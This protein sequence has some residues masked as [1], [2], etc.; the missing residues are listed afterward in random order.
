MNLFESIET[1]QNELSQ[2]TNPKQW[3]KRNQLKS[4]IKTLIDQLTNP[5]LKFKL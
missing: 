1:K 3:E 2:L 5:N 4:E